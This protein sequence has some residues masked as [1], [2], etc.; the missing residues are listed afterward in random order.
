MKKFWKSHKRE[1]YAKLHFIQYYSRNFFSRMYMSSKSVSWGS[2]GAEDPPFIKVGSSEPTRAQS[3]EG[4]S[5]LAESSRMFFVTV[6]IDS[7]W[8]AFALNL[9]FFP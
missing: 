9:G 6:L 2:R 8:L 1:L 7:D 3:R 4:S 5:S